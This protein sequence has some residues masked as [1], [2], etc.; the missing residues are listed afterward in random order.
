MRTYARRTARRGS[1]SLPYFDEA[2]RFSADPRVVS[3]LATLTVARLLRR[4]RPPRTR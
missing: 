2:A 1:L 4:P 3:R